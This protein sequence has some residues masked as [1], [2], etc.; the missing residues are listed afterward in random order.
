M[1]KKSSKK[2]AE[3]QKDFTIDMND[4][5]HPN[6]ARSQRANKNDKGLEEVDDPESKN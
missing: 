3:D 4:P 2:F 6:Y 5:N 1:N